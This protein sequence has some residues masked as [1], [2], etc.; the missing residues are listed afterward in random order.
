MGM[1]VLVLS[2]EVTHQRPMS[3]GLPAEW[4]CRTISLIDPEYATLHEKYGD[5]TCITPFEIISF[6]KRAYE[7]SLTLIKEF[8]ADVI[9]GVGHGAHVLSNLNI[10]YEWRGPSVFIF[11]EGSARF[12]FVPRPQ[13]DEV[14]FNTQPVRSARVVIGDKARIVRQGSQGRKQSTDRD[15]GT[16]VHIQ[17]PGANWEKTLYSSGMLKTLLDIVSQSQS[18]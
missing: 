12:N 3:Y 18:H 8:D 4:E 6:L 15:R 13:P 11:S 5:A 9:V 14:E 17:I 7:K 16:I 10:S 2:G 1:K